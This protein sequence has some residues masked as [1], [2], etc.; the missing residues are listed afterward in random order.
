MPKEIERKFLVTDKSWR[1]QAGRGKPIRQAYLVLNG[2]TLVRV[3]I[4]GRA[5]ALLTIKSSQPDASRSEFEYPIPVKDARELMKLRTGR[6]IE[7]HRHIVKTGK[8]R[9]EV[10]VFKGKHRGLV[11]AE[12][13]LKGE[14][15]RFNRPEW[16][17]KE[18]TGKKRYYNA[19]MASS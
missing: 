10:D 11:L 14:R 9:F 15:A 7:K 2:K 3:R 19:N 5:K 8:E 6:I 12:I 1:K 17:G 4:V 13:E 18:V 16:L